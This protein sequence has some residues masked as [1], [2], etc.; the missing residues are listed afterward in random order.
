M[1]SLVVKIR[2]SLSEDHPTRRLRTDDCFSLC[3]WPSSFHTV[4]CT[5]SSRHPYMYIGVSSA[6]PA[7]FKRRL[8]PTIYIYIYVSRST[9]TCLC[10]M[11]A[12][13]QGGFACI[14]F[15]QR[16]GLMSLY[17]GL[18]RKKR[19]YAL[20]NHFECRRTP[21]P[22]KAAAAADANTCTCK[23]LQLLDAMLEDNLALTYRC[24][25]IDVYVQTYMHRCIRVCRAVD[26]YMYV[27]I[28]AYVLQ[29]RQCIDVYAQLYILLS[30]LV[31]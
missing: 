24:I 7:T 19:A 10:E 15:T 8:V 12:C 31:R 1:L 3:L 22:A 14:R 21:S 9:Y 23:E 17:R 25:C 13:G 26:V 20:H 11:P 18:Q 2:Q 29:M 16:G 27:Y 30:D 6:Y 4:L 28:H 5:I